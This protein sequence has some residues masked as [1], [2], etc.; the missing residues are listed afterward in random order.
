MK[1]S[2]HIILGAA[3]IT[4]FSCRGGS[5]EGSASMKTDNESVVSGQI[6]ITKDQFKEAGMVVGDPPREMFSNEVPA[7]GFVAAAIGGSARINTL[8]PGRVRRIN[9]AEGETV[10]KGEVLFSMESNEFIMLQQEYAEVHQQVHLL[11]ANYQRQKALYEEKILAEKDFLRTESE[12]R[13]MLSK[14]EGLGARLRMIHVDPGK[15]ES[16]SIEPFLTIRS[17][18]PGTIT[19]QELVLGQFLDPQTTVMEVVDG[20]KLQLSLRVFEQS[21]EEVAIGQVVH[22]NTPDHPETIY[23]G[24]LSHVGKSIDPETKTVHCIARLDPEIG[25]NFVNNLYV[26]TR[27]ITCKREVWAVPENAIIKEP[28]YDFVWTLV[29]ET[30]EEFVFR[31][32]PVQ[33]GVTRGGYT[34][35][36]D[37]DLSSV[38]LVGAYNLWSED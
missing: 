19:H 22:F 17:P 1:H 13:R 38:L 26:E 11:E 31:K 24:I 28:D 3:L 33:T 37:E 27:I 9:H 35:V 14:K 12:Y 15:I 18:I 2:L 30:V 4:F 16:G 23:E 7:N 5:G 10:G 32:I 21:L 25:E 8:V 6:V 34:E 36:L 20:R 29:D